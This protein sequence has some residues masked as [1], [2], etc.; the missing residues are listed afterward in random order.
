MMQGSVPVQ[1][2]DDADMILVGDTDT[3]I[4]KMKRYADLGID[5]L[6]CYVQWGYLEHQA[7]LRTIDILGKEVIPEMARYQARV[8]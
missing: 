4:R 7:I 5:Q 3:I 2:F 8:A 6:I 1:A